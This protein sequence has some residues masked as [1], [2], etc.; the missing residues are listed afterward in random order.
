M[1]FTKKTPTEQ[2][3][4]VYRDMLDTIYDIAKNCAEEGVENEDPFVEI[5]N[6]AYWLSHK[7]ADVKI[8]T[9][10]KAHKKGKTQKTNKTKKRA[11][12]A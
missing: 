11:K 10:C 9:T 5:I 6:I 8:V 4:M 2:K 7:Y 12:S 1:K 3:V